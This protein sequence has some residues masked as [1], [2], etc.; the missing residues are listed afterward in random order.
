M[1]RRMM[2]AWLVTTGIVCGQQ[3]AAPDQAVTRVPP[4]RP[5]VLPPRIG[6]ITDRQLTLDDALAM[7][8]ANNKDIDG[9]RIDRDKA[10]N[11]VSGAKGYYD[12][13][14]GGVASFQKNI[15]PVASSLG[16][17]A[18]GSVINRN[19]LADPQLSGSLP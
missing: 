19:G 16:G 18:T 13:R 2:L 12:P 14:I 7:A 9:S 4:A 10:A 1:S 15:T 3:Q 11:S 6:V 17:S 5:F 8:L